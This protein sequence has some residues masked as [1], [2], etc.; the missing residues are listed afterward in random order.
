V[1]FSK[2]VNERVDLLRM[3]LNGTPRGRRKRRRLNV[4]VKTVLRYSG[5]ACRGLIWLMTGKRE[6]LL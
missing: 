1:S 5:S 3:W 6:G 4:N 2:T